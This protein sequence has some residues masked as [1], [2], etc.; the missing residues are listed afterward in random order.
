MAD[1]DAGESVRLSRR[2]LLGGAAAGFGLFF[3]AQVGRAQVAVPAKGRTRLLDP[4]RVPQ[5]ATSLLIPPSNRAGLEGHRR[6]PSGA[7]QAPHIAP[8]DVSSAR[9]LAA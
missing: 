1:G 3:V 8:R 9:R 4:R 6:R 5:F 7:D 2:Q